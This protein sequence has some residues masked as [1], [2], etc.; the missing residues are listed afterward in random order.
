MSCVPKVDILRVCGPCVR[1]CDIL[2]FTSVPCFLKPRLSAK[3]SPTCDPPF[4]RVT[5]MGVP[6]GWEINKVQ[7]RDGDLASSSGPE[8]ALN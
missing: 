2:N 6:Q 3:S 4:T 7:F 1:G 8:K 5:A